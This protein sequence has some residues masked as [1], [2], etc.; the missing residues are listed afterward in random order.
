MQLKVST[1]VVIRDGGAR[2]FHEIRISDHAIIINVGLPKNA[3]DFLRR[4]TLAPILQHMTQLLGRN[5][6]FCLGVPGLER[7]HHLLG[8]VLN[9][10]VDVHD[11]EK[12]GEGHFAALLLEVAGQFGDRGGEPQASHY[13]GELVQGFDVARTGEEVEA[14]SEFWKQWG[15]KAGRVK[16]A[17]YRRCLAP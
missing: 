14:F 12:V 9:P 2:D 8:E 7:V 16:G 15:D 3:V 6:P 11:L 5:D 10:G 1:L 4:Q 17:A 13:H